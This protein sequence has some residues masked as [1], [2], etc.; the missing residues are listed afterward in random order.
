[1]LQTGSGAVVLL[2]YRGGWRSEQV[3]SFVSQVAIPIKR[4]ASLATFQGVTVFILLIVSRS[5]KTTKRRHISAA[6]PNK[7]Q[8][9]HRI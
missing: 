9:R 1:M 2:E 5:Q 6:L 7:D 3:S 8:L 4:F